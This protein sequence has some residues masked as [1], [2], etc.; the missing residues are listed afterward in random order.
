MK[1]ALAIV[2]MAAL[3]SSVM[4]AGDES[5]QLK[6]F[7]D[8][9]SC[10]TGC[11]PKVAK[12]LSGLQGAKDVKLTDFEAGLFTMSFDAKAELKPAAF[13]K[14]LGE[15]KVK[16]IELTLSGTIARVKEDIIL[17][18]VAGSKY[19]LV[20]KEGCTEEKADAKKDAPKTPTV[21]DP[22]MA[23]I[24]S[25]LKENKTSVKVT[26]ALSECCEVTIAV[27]AIDPV[28]AKKPAN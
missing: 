2:V 26:G 25:L 10:P 28:E 18:T 7:V 5:V 19:P 23:R 11:A 12:G 16:K 6:V 22:I 13:Q 21:V 20:C 27:S 24:E 8:G 9:M 15:Y 4:A 14:A 17:T 3:G 1:Q